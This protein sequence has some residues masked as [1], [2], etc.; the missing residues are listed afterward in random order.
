LGDAKKI[1]KLVVFNN[2]KYVVSEPEEQFTFMRYLDHL[3][4]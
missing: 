1:S 4:Y 2:E 3:I